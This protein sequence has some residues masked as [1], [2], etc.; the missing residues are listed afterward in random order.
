MIAAV[1][2]SS[3]DFGAPRGTAE[4]ELVAYTLL[5][6]DIGLFVDVVGTQIDV[7]SLADGE[8]QLKLAHAE[9]KRIF[10]E[11]HQPADVHKFHVGVS[12]CAGR[13]VARDADVVIDPESDPVA[14]IARRKD[15]EQ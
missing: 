2:M 10:G 1:L 12:Q 6:S 14:E 7:S 8:V 15:A 3:T 4:G 9:A 13:V 11:P 5:R